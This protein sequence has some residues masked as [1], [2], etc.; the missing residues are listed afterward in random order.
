MKN[1]PHILLLTALLMSAVSCKKEIDF[2][3]H[4]GERHV[5]V[6][7]QLDPDSLLC[8]N[9]A[10]TQFFLDPGPVQTIN[11]A[12]MTLWVNGTEHHPA[13]VEN[14]YYHFGFKPQP[15]DSVWFQAE[16]PGEG[17]VEGGTRVVASPDISNVR[18]TESEAFAFVHMMD[19]YDVRFQL[20][21][22][23]TPGDY[24]RIQ[25]FEHIQCP[26]YDTVEAVDTIRSSMF[27]FLGLNEVGDTTTPGLENAAM[28]SDV[29]LSD[30]L[31]TSPSKDI[32]LV[33]MP[34]TDT[35]G[36]LQR[37]YFVR[38]TS[39]SYDMAR[40][41]STMWSASSS[42][43]MFS[44]PMQVYTN[45]TGGIGVFGSTSKRMVK[46]TYIPREEDGSDRRSN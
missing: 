12:Q 2:T 21:D 5:V 45:I 20:V 46:A 27:M 30:K 29:L 13:S 16:V 19:M 42:I 6:M 8:V 7:A 33:T 15:G 24:Y 32:V 34:I 43:S 23:V 44:E 9:L 25:L 4:E 39:Y 37:D 31:F 3:G 41:L 35:T 38:V 1:I 26:A 18:Y 36:L 10:Y 14:G 28:A 22:P 11:D 17:L 40:Y